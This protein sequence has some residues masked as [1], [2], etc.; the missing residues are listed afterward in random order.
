MGGHI[1]IFLEFNSLSQVLGFDVW[2][3]VVLLGGKWKYR[4]ECFYFQNL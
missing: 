1:V 4:Y 2:G 3:L